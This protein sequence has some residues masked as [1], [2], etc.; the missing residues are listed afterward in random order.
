M[1]IQDVIDRILAYHPSVEGYRGCDQFKCGYPEDECTGIVT[2]MAP[3]MDVIREAVRLRSN[4]ILVHEP[5]NYTSMD[6]PGWHEDFPNH[7]YAEKLRLLNEHRIAIW[8][9]HDHMHMHQPDGIFTG[10]LKYM[11]WEPYAEVD[12]SMG[13]FNHFIVNLPSPISLKALMRSLKT[14][15]GTHGI[16]YIGPED[17]PVGK[18][19]IVGHLYPMPFPP[20]AKEER[21]KEYSVQIIKYF[22]EQ[23]VDVILP[24]ETIDWTVLSYVRDAI[25]QGENK[26]VIT[27]GH[28]NWE[29]LGM[30]YALEWVQPLVGDILKVTYVPS[31][32]MYDY[33]L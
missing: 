9:D 13:M 1:T 4:L 28:F 15:I 31:G 25:Q 29:E 2:A 20:H 6:M 32:D 21:P 7:V 23:Q 17:M 5:T 26:A 11:G 18:I 12:R 27:L 24:G 14:T 22:E 16:R 30:R 10:V 8:R 33:F 19:A 3:T